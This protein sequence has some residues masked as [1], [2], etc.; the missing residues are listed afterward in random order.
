MTTENVKPDKIYPGPLF[1]VSVEGEALRKLMRTVVPGDTLTY[2]RIHEEVG[3]DVRQQ[4]GLWQSASEQLLRHE[5]IVFQ[6]VPGEGYRRC[7]DDEIVGKTTA[8][9]E[10]MHRQARRVIVT[11]RA[12]DQAALDPTMRRELATNVT[13]AGAI[14]L[15]TAPAARQARI[16]NGSAPSL[17]E[18][19]V[20]AQYADLEHKP[21]RALRKAGGRA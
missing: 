19:M 10:A 12:A 21:R 16:A 18:S 2:A 13:I 4:R 7:T 3:V 11:A 17:T 20:Q 15:E 9:L 1:T 5:R 8:Q 14:A 6:A